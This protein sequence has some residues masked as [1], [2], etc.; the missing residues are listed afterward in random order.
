MLLRNNIL[1]GFRGPFALI[2]VV[3]QQIK[4]TNI[5]V[6]IKES[7]KINVLHDST[8]MKR[9]WYIFFIVIMNSTKQLRTY[10]LNQIQITNFC[11]IWS[12]CLREKD[13]HTTRTAG[14]DREQYRPRDRIIFIDCFCLLRT[15]TLIYNLLLWNN[16]PHE[17]VKK[18]KISNSEV[19]NIF[20]EVTQSAVVNSR[21]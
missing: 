20:N 9:T 13:R 16:P 1:P 6:Y 18:P 8:Y 3:E 15:L 10:T 11:H 14:N 7:A 21:H 5:L 12:P 2:V 4:N 17:R 19:E